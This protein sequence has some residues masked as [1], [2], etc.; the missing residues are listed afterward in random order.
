M[1]RCADGSG[2]HCIASVRSEY[3]VVLWP[4]LEPHPDAQAFAQRLRRE[5]RPYLA[6]QTISV[7]VGPECRNLVDYGDAYQVTCAAIDLAQEAHLT[8]NVVSLGDL[9]IYRLLLQ[10]KR[11]ADLL[12]FARSVLGKLA[13][14]DSRRGTELVDTLRAYMAGG[15]SASEAATGLHIHTNTVSYRLR[16]IQTLLDV[17][18]RKPADLL[19]IELALMVDRLLGGLQE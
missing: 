15:C 7:A 4:T 11:P 5:V 19:M 16:R 17:D 13:E 1:Q 12:D 18:L 14:Y 2:V 9:G 6:G 8:D 10:V 3:V